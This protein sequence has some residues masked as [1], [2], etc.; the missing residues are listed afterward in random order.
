[1]AQAV[2]ESF[3]SWYHMLAG[4]AALSE[5]MTKGPRD[6]SALSEAERARFVPTSMTLPLCAQDA[7]DERRAGSSSPDLRCGWELVMMNL[8]NAPGGRTFWQERSYLFGSEF[9]DHFEN[10]VMKR[11]PHPSAKPPGAFSIVSSDSWMLLRP[12]GSEADWGASRH[13]RAV[14]AFCAG[15]RE[16][17][18]RQGAGPEAERRASRP[19]EK[20]CS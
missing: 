12:T 5:L 10:E 6:Y 2:H 15:T 17:R 8:V 20:R 7:F 18:A 3:A 4:E 16:N 19:Q 9:R 14:E 13:V 11:D 1:L